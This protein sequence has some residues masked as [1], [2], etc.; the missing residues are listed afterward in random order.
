MEW[1]LPNLSQAKRISLDTEGELNI[2]RGGKP[3]GLSIATDDFQYSWYIPFAHRSGFNFEIEKVISWANDNLVN[4]DIDLLNSKHDFNTLRSIGIDLEALGNR[5]HDVMHCPA[6]LYSNRQSYALNDLALEA[7]GKHKVELD[8]D[9]D[10]FPMHE[11]NSAAVRWYA[12]Y[13]AELTAELA[14]YYAPKIKEQGLSKVLELEDN[15][16]YCVAS[17]EREGAILDVEKL[18]L[19]RKQAQNRYI[20]S[21][22]NLHKMVSAR[23]E[24]TKPQDLAK[25][26]TILKIEYNRTPSGLPSFT[27]EFLEQFLHIEPVRIAYEARQI[28]SLKSKFLDKYA[29]AVGPDGKIRYALNQLKAT[30]NEGANQGTVTGRFSSSGG[31]KHIGGINVQQVFGDEKQE[32]IP[33]IEDF[34]IRELF[35]PDSGKL[36]LSADARQIEFRIFA[37]LSNSPRLLQAYYDDPLINFHHLVAKDIL[38]VPYSKKVKN[39]NFGSMYEMG[40]EKLANIYLKIPVEE[41]RPLFEHYHREFPEVKMLSNRAAYLAQSRRTNNPQDRGWVKT[42]LGRKRT[43]TDDDLKFSLRSGK[44]EIPYYTALNAV[45]QGTAADIMKLKLLEVYNSRKETGIT[46]RFTVHDEVDGDIPDYASAR[47]VANILN[48]QTLP[49]NVPILWQTT[50]GPSWANLKDID[51]PEYFIGPLEE[52]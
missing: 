51:G 45:I 7:L 16:I 8:G 33:C 47:K 14:A 26:F 28:A 24:P 20:Q 39:M 21:I 13:D 3:C 2:W 27:N 1:E 29:N 6:L 4:L 19:W 52:F 30:N 5:L 43:Y 9:F 12:R 40:L 36:W 44:K 17:M 23:I 11:R 18:E 37:H 41:A 50:I 15:L 35:R 25:L 46:M 10:R 48:T 22:L 34:P 32:K 38:H 31:G 42:I 49:L